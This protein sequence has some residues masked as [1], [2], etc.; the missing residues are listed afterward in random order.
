LLRRYLFDWR[1]GLTLPIALLLDGRGAVRK[2]YPGIPDAAQLREDYQARGEPLPFP[3]K[4]YSGP[5]RSYFK[6]GAAFFW[7]GYPEQALLYLEE[8]L[9]RSPDNFKAILAVGQ[10]HLEQGRL[11]AARPLL[12][13]AVKLNPKSPEAWNN[14]GGVAG[15]RD[16]V[17]HYERALELRPDFI[18]ALLNAGQA[19]M[20]LN[21]YP[22]AERRFQ[23]AAE[24]DSGNPDA[25]NQLGLAYAKQGRTREAREWFQKAIEIKRDHAGAINNLGVLYGELRQFPDA[26][27]AFEYGIS[28][29]PDD[30]TLYMNLG[31]VYV[32]LGEQ[33]KA[34]DVMRRL[35]ARKPA[36]TAAKRALEMLR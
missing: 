28:A 21:D 27:A 22:A 14:L 29:A 31:R 35:L 24:L 7:A 33:E 10:I 11:D 34:R 6:L 25:A 19:S 2:F 36:N 8:A 26:I 4:Y 5:S 13:R 20:Q 30:D 23:K 15:T 1:T 32:A 3:G 12:E 17:R 16:A 18:P 9:R